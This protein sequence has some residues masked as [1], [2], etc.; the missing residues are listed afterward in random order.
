MENV[1]LR[2]KMAIKYTIL[3]ASILFSAEKSAEYREIGKWLKSAGEFCPHLGEKVEDFGQGFVD[4]NE[5]LSE[6]MSQEAFKLHEILGDYGSL[7]FY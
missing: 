5:L 1:E 6:K 7:S 4:S 2:W 3:V